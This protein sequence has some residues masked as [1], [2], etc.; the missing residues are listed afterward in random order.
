MRFE[1][2]VHSHR[3][4][5]CSVPQNKTKSHPHFEVEKG[6]EDLDEIITINTLGV[7]KTHRRCLGS[8][9]LIESPNSEV[10][11]RTRRVKNWQD[12]AMVVRWVAVSLLEREERF[13]R[14]LGHQHLWMLDAK[15]KELAGNDT[16]DGKVQVA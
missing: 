10:H 13:R 8:T 5:S 2:N 9:N 6:D 11:N 1:I 7:P 3:L 4:T 12:H 16:F 14:I 15:L